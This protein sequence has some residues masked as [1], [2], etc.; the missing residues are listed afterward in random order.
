MDNQ[1]TGKFSRITNNFD[2]I[3]IKKINY[4]DS[5]LQSK[6]ENEKDVVDESPKKS[7][8]NHKNLNSQKMFSIIDKTSD[9]F[10]IKSDNNKQVE[11]RKNIDMEKTNT[12]KYGFKP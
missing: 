2:D 8:S 1:S 11:E 9:L 4:I 3:D 12:N 7:I 5:S 10:S 6:K